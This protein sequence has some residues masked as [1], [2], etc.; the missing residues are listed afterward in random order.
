M[1]LNG[2]RKNDTVCIQYLC[3][4][5]PSEGSVKI[6]FSE[7]VRRKAHVAGGNGRGADEKLVADDFVA[8]T[9]GRGWR[10]RIFG[11]LGYSSAFASRRE[12]DSG[13]PFSE[14]VG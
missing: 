4:T 11:D 1:A 8:R 3:I 6:G 7:P 13:C 12:E 10:R 5:Y 9:I 2:S 14:I